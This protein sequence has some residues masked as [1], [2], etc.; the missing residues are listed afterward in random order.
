[1][2]NIS[3]PVNPKEAGLTS[4]ARP[5]PAKAAQARTPQNNAG[6][7]NFIFNITDYSLPSPRAPRQYYQR[8]IVLGQ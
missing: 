8:I 6:E 3:G 5:A 7:K 1:M 2:G 4:S